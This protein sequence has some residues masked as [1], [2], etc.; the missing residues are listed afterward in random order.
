MFVQS[1]M[2]GAL[3]DPSEATDELTH[4][5]FVQS[6]MNGALPD[7]S[8]ATDELTHDVFLQVQGSNRFL[9]LVN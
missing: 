4:D 2:N 9:Q 5:V 8:E 3:P 6:D 1:D 7:P